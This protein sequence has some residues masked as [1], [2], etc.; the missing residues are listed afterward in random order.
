MIPV[1]LVIAGFVLLIKGAEFL[2]DGSSNIAKKFR[3]PEIVIGLTIVSIGTSLPELGVSITSLLKGYSDM[4]IGNVLGSSIC[5][6]LLILGISSIIRPIR[7]K[8]ETRIIEIPLCLILTIIFAIFC[9]TLNII[10]KYEAM[11][12]IVLFIMFLIYTI[13]MGRKGEKFDKED[14]DSLENKIENLKEK[15]IL[16]SIIYIVVGII[17]LKFGGDFI[18]DNAAIIA[19]YFNLSEK[20]ISLTILALGTSLPELVTSVV[21]TARGN[22]DISIGNIIGSNIFN[23]TLITG[24]SALIKPI[25]FNFAYNLELYLLILASALL[26]IFTLI[27]PRNKMT[28]SRGVI[29]LGLYFIYMV[30]ML[31]HKNLSFIGGF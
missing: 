22:S 26:L 4:S 31:F 18:V 9:N 12:L 28:R 17:A 24:I 1:I 23:I 21:A 20:I 27:R 7:L 29:Y 3:I 10:S 5:N 19:E 11:V 15:S 2:V 30:I 6:L 8:K 13:I 16:R 14:E 25:I